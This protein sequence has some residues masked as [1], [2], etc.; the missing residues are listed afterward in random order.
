MQK[1][2]VLFGG[3]KGNIKTEPMDCPEPFCVCDLLWWELCRFAV[4]VC[5]FL[6]WFLE[7]RSVTSSSCTGRG[8]Q[9]DL[10]HPF[11]AIHDFLDYPILHKSS[12][13]VW[14]AL[15][16]LVAHR[17]K[18]LQTLWVTL[19]AHL[20][21]LPLRLCQYLCS[22]LELSMSVVSFWKRKEE[23]SYEFTQVHERSDIWECLSWRILCESW[24]V[25]VL[26]SDGVFERQFRNSFLISFILDL[27]CSL[28]FCII[29][30]HF[31]LR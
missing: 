14:S 30:I 8:E 3:I 12:L 11:C 6:A 16:C 10:I 18:A 4:D 25:K 24:K 26:C 15:S 27:V 23:R 13:S 19:V 5:L 28:A 7:H 2:L 20:L 1:V 31:T 21:L 22:C 9:S 29:K 17:L